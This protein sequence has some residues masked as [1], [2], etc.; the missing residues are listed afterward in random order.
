MVVLGWGEGFI[1]LRCILVEAAAP[2]AATQRLGVQPRM[3][4][5]VEVR[6]AY[7]AAA[8]AQRS[9]CT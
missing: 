3:K 8:A 5:R 4:R 6:P 7:L 1:G 2:R 9:T